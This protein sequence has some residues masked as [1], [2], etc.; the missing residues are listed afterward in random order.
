MKILYV[1]TLANF[2]GT[3]NIVK[4]IANHLCVDNN[5]VVATGEDG[6]MLKAID[7]PVK[8]IILKHLG[9]PVRPLKDIKAFFELRKLYWKEKPDMIHLFSS[10]GLVLGSLAFPAKRIIWSINGFDSLRKKYRKFLFI[11]R[12]MRN[13]NRAICVES[14]YD[15]Q[16]MI[17]EGFVKNNIYI[18]RNGADP[19]QILPDVAINGI[20]KYCKVVMNIARIAPQKRFESFV[21]IAKMLPQYAF[22]WIGADKDY[23]KLPP[24]LFCL[25]GE[26]NA[27]R[28]LQLTDIFVLPTNYEGLPLAIVEAL[29]YSK[30]IVASDVGAISEIVLNGQNGYV[31]ENDNQLFAQKIRYILENEA[32]YQQFSTK[33]LEIFQSKLTKEV[34][35]AGYKQVYETVY[36]SI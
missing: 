26:S 4:D 10:K 8:K 22:V 5:I 35:L 17:K 9:R 32:T 20:E 25:K 6:P 18:I 16:N 27:K 23:D 24:N 21:E 12:L 19:C 31:L 13:K 15:E 7:G 34:T 1:I 2:G 3:Q 29:S 30:P 11:L 33:S 28:Y 36:H 14:N